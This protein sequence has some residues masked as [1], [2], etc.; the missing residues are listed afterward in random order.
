MTTDN[1]QSSRKTPGACEGIRIVEIGTMVTAPYAGQLQGDN[2]AEELKIEALNGEVM[3]P[4]PGVYQRQ[5]A[6][7]AQWNRDAKSVALKL[8]DPDAVKA[9]HAIIP[10]ADAV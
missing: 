5:S 3:R 8:K 1:K 7:F 4:V 6:A 2:G 9:A 10:T